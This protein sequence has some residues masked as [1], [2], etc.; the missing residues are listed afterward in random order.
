MFF[1]THNLHSLRGKESE[2]NLAHFSSLRTIDTLYRETV[3]CIPEVG[4]GKEVIF[5]SIHTHIHTLN[6]GI[7][8]T[9][10]VKL[11]NVRS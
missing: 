9:P 4:S 1:M 11:S 7:E 5:S 3:K 6:G 2:L 10:R 8:E